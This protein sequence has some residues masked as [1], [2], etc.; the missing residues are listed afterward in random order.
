M[1]YPLT[2]LPQLLSPPL[3]RRLVLVGAWQPDP[4]CQPHLHGTSARFFTVPLLA[5]APATS[6]HA[7]SRTQV[8]YGL[9]SYQFFVDR[10]EEE[11]RHLLMFFGSSYDKYQQRVPSGVPFVR[12]FRVSDSVR[13]WWL[14]QEGS[15]PGT[16]Q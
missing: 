8:A 2:Y 5:L 13:K 14:A 16:G 6:P 15:G 7:S 10:V 11:E 1:F 12:G 3:L 4:P 9:A